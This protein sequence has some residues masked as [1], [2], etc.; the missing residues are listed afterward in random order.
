MPIPRS[1]L[2]MTA[3]ELDGFLS[4]ERTA[5]VGTVSRSG[6]PHVAPLWFVWVDGAVFVSSLRRSR[7]TSDLRGGSRAAVCVDAG[8]NYA[9]L[10]G[11]VL[12]GTFQPA[13]DHPSLNEVRRVFG[14]KYLG[15][16]ET[17]DRQSH[18]WLVLKPDRIVSWDF[19]K[20]PAGRDRHARSGG[21]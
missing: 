19:R 18:D 10:K 14:E 16:N 13:N 3:E 6:E 8:E 17:P 12:Y 15:G 20:I 21:A 5:R 4:T 1:V 2:R 7:R 9:E 11:A